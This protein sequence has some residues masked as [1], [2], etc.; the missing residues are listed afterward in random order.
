MEDSTMTFQPGGLVYKS[1]ADATLSGGT[2]NGNDP[3][4]DPQADPVQSKSRAFHIRKTRLVAGLDGQCTNNEPIH[5]DA[6][7]S[8]HKISFQVAKT[9]LPDDFGAELDKI[10]KFYDL[11]LQEIF[12]ITIDHG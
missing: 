10:K 5:F 9:G 2:Q 12:P 4:T 8:K 7:P 1:V 11:Y 3:C 6:F